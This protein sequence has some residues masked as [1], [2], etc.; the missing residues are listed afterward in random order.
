VISYKI[1]DNS[2]LQVTF[3]GNISYNEIVNWLGEFSTIENLTLHIKLLYDLTKA[4]LL[5]DMIKLIH[6]TK[7]TEEVTKNF[8][9]VKTVFLIEEA[10]R[11]TFSLLFSFLDTKGK[12]IRKLFT[13]YEKSTERL[14]QE[15]D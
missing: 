7:K 1:L 5:I 15:T 10:D 4:K 11:S 2:I 6:I 8:E 3:S 9:S 14:L 12:T 13:S